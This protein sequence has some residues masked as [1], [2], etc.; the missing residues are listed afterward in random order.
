MS[1]TLP[2]RV[3]EP[4]FRP[5]LRRHP[6][7]RPL[8]AYELTAEDKRIIL[9]VLPTLQTARHQGK[10]H[11]L[12]DTDAGGRIKGPCTDELLAEAGVVWERGNARYY[13]IIRELLRRT[14]R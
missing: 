12:R 7:V 4:G 13:A 5:N 11:D 1:S 10:R 3:C 8:K 9:R 6:D 14:G 2:D